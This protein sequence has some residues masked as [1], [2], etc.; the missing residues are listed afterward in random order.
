MN[1]NLKQNEDMETEKEMQADV[2]IVGTG[3]AGLLLP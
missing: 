1:R 2:V 3:A